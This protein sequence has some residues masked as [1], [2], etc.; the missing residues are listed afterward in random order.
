MLRVRMRTNRLSR[1]DSRIAFV[2]AWM[3]WR[4]APPGP[5]IKV[6]DEGDSTMNK[7]Q[8]RMPYA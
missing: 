4:Y 3:A 1:S 5:S 7:R 6:F 2:T 8:R